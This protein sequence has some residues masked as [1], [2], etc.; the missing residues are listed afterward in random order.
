[1]ALEGER[2]YRSSMIRRYGDGETAPFLKEHHAAALARQDAAMVL[3]AGP[4]TNHDHILQFSYH[5]LR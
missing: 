5:V 3:P 2:K 1:M 4:A